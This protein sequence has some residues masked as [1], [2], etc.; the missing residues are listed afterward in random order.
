MREGALVI[1]RARGRGLVVVVAAGCSA[2]GQR[3]A[4]MAL[5]GGAASYGGTAIYR[6]RVW[7]GQMSLLRWYASRRRCSVRVVSVL[8]VETACWDRGALLYV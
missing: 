1:R 6:G 3:V 5:D 2:G 7:A 4:G 8:L